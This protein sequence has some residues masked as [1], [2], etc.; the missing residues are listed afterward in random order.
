MVHEFCY[1]LLKFVMFSMVLLAFLQ[2]TQF[3]KQ[4]Y[5]RNVMFITDGSSE[6][7][8]WADGM[9]IISVMLCYS[10]LSSYAPSIEPVSKSSR[11][12]VY[13]VLGLAVRC[14]GHGVFALL[15]C[16]P[17]LTLC[18]SELLFHDID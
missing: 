10:I 3:L 2:S 13:D 15:I 7:L 16:R 4:E 8:M 14:K 9:Y 18:W 17:I 12:E 11:V 5:H 1:A 6:R